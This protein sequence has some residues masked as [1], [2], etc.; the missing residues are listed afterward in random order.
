[1][2]TRNLF[3]KRVRFYYPSNLNSPFSLEEFSGK[4]WPKKLYSASFET[5]DYLASKGLVNPWQI[6][7][8]NSLMDPDKRNGKPPKNGDWR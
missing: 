8:R 7:R 2:S 3:L 6:N 4:Q 5:P 1:M